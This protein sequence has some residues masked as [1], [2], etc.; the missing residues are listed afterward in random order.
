MKFPNWLAVYGDVTYRGQ[1]PRE[2]IEQITAFNRIRG[3]YPD[4]LGVI[5]LHPRNE[6]KRSHHKAQREK[7]E[8]MAP[9]ASDLIIPGAPAFVC[10]IKRRDHTKSQWEDHQQ[11]YLWAARQQ[12]TF[13]CV[14]LGA[15]AVMEALY[16]WLDTNY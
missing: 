9:G 2:A 15:D 13:V 14:A 4:T 3:A 11:D 10:E 8:G 7:A 16:V 6:A 1:C 5:A 12:G